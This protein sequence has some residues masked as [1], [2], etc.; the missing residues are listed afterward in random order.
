MGHK[1]VTVCIT[2][3]NGADYLPWCLDAVQKLDPALSEII[4]VDNASTDHSVALLEERYSHIKLIT[5][6]H[7]EGPCPARNIGLEAASH[8]LVFQIDCDVA[9]QQDCL[10]R[11]VRAMEE[12]GEDVAACQP[13]GV[14][15]DRRD[16]IHYEGAHFHYLGLLT[17]IRF[18]EPVPTD[19]ADEPP[20]E[21]NA[22]IS[23]AMLLKRDEVLGIGG[24]D[25]SYF[26]LF[27]DHDLCYRLQLE[28]KKILSVPQALVYHR[29]GTKG[30]SFRADSYPEQRAFLHSRNRLILLLKNHRWRTLLLTAPSLVLFDLVWFFFSVREGFLLA[31]IRGKLSFLRMI[32]R[33]LGA[34]RIIQRS[35]RV[36]DRD[37]L[38][39]RDLTYSPLIRKSGVDRFCER[40]LNRFLRA[41]WR[42]VKPLAG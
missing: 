36:R 38:G 19:A 5:I 20:Q 16:T 26:I 27:E 3:Y 28:G 23:M 37:L 10:G 2:N 41:W 8:P 6:E 4:V 17:L 42:L 7:N 29:E 1:P 30:V 15:N 21:M 34:R 24:Y 39:A 13:R 25:P 14:F 31:F 40:L 32:P 9:P 22:A 12:G 18:Y 35:R 11:L 33:L